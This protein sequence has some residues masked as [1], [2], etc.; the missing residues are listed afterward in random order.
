M[1]Y[2]GLGT[3]LRLKNNGR[4][5][6]NGWHSWHCFV[7]YEIILRASPHRQT[8]LSSVLF[9][10]SFLFHVLVSRPSDSGSC[11]TGLESLRTVPSPLRS[12]LQPV[13]WPQNRPIVLFPSAS[14]RLLV[15]WRCPF[16]FRVS[17]FVDLVAWCLYFFCCCS[18]I[19]FV[20]PSSSRLMH[21]LIAFAEQRSCISLI[22]FLGCFRCN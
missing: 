7:I 13:S 1:D 17:T 6:H 4:T 9:L 11:V 22:S 20:P 8:L 19:A 15:T 12:A 2:P 5:D 18:G 3:A 16:P 10:F 14:N 21:R